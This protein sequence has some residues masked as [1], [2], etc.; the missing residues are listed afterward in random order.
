MLSLSYDVFD[1]G[2]NMKS[3]KI[4]IAVFTGT[5]NTLMMARVLAEA[6][7]REGRSVSLVPMERTDAFNLPDGAALGLAVPVACFSTY[8]TALRFIDALPEG[9][10]REAFFLATMGG[11]AFGME[12]PVRRVLERKGY[13][14]IGSKIVVM[15]SNYNNKKIPELE[16]QVKISDAIGAI[17]VFAGELVNGEA[18]WGEGVVVSSLMARLGRTRFPWRAFYR[19]FPLAVDAKKCT[20]CGVCRD[21]CPEE[22]I[23]MSEDVARIGDRCQSCQ[24]CCGFCPECAISVPGKPAERYSSVSLDKLKNL[25]G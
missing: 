16:N 8:P 12:G 15:P 23:L 13:E 25:I 4:V 24:R 5:G 6:L 18:S 14:P 7:E 2:E 20:G 22:N 21:L 3:E 19:V 9:E 1:G 17:K 10:G 11:V